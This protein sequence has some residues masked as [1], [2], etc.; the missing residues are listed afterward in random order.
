MLAGGSLLRSGPTQV[1]EPK[2]GE[3]AQW[4]YYALDAEVI[5]SLLVHC[6]LFPRAVCLILSADEISS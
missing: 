5:G 6:M 2:T 4:N 1:G 3:H